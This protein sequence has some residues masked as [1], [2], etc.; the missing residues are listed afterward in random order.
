MTERQVKEL[1]TKKQMLDLKNELYEMELEHREKELILRKK[2]TE[3]NIKTYHYKPYT[4]KLPKDP[5]YF[6]MYQRKLY[7][8][9]LCKKTTCEICGRIVATGGL[10]NHQKKLVCQS[11]KS[12]PSSVNADDG[13]CIDE[14]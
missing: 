14:S 4:E 3:L 6:K 7:Q 11:K 9:K 8:E 2:I 1:E 13:D 12:E 10:K 5:E